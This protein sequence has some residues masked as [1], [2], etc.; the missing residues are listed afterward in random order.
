MN[1]KVCIGPV[2]PMWFS[3]DAMVVCK[4]KWNCIWGTTPFCHR[5]CGYHTVI[6]DAWYFFWWANSSTSWYEHDSQWLKHPTGYP[7]YVHQHHHA[8]WVLNAKILVQVSSQLRAHV[9]SNSS[10]CQL[11]WCQHSQRTVQ[12]NNEV[13]DG[14][15]GLF[16]KRFVG[17][18]V[19]I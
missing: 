10:K 11:L 18:A 3:P 4:M 12:S 1:M 19:W 14:V 17:S 6:H 9:Q 7:D 2:Q 16:G 5:H 15:S 13:L 8:P